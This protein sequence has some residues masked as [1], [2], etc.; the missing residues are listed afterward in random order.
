MIDIDKSNYAGLLKRFPEQIKEATKIARN[1]KV[2]DT[3]TN[4]VVAGMGASG[5]S[6]EILK[7]Y[8]PKLNIKVHHNYGLPEHTDRK[9]L[10]FICS[11]SGNTEEIIDAFR[12]GVKQNASMI[13]ITSG[14]KLQQL[15]KENKKTLVMIPKGYPPRAS[16]AHQFFTML[17]ILSN[18]RLIEDQSGPIQQ[19]I[20][21]LESPLYD[22]RGKELAATLIDKIPLIYT[23]ERIQSVG[24]R[25]KTNFNENAKT[26]AFNNVIPELNHNEI[27][28]FENPKGNFHVILLRDEED[29]Y[30]ISKRMKAMK[31]V[32]K[33]RKVS[34][35]EIALKGDYF[36]TRIFAAIL[37]GNWASYHLAIN[38]EIDPEPVSLIEEF[39]KKIK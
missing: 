5:I 35:S 10:L 9:T 37:M 25:W 18:S 20:K 33:S 38:Y 2:F 1:T 29:G 22:E 4:V 12:K 32:I 23:S 28:A 19:T 15:A 30:T 34:I 24:K 31:E 8:L 14:G 13:I 7:D 26:M 36:L 16:L 21:T 39:K 17:T 3:I 11:Y 27:E 6:G